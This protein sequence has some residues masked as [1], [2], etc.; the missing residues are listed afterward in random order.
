MT[1]GR[2]SA[3]QAPARDVF[4][5]SC[6]PSPIKI[7]R[8]RNS[9]A[10]G[11]DLHTMDLFRRI[12]S[13]RTGGRASALRRLLYVH[14]TLL[15]FL[16]GCVPD[17]PQSI[18]HDRGGSGGGDSVLQISIEPSGPIDSA[19]PILRARIAFEG[20]SSV[21]LERVFFVEG[22]IGPA[23]LRQIEKGALSK[24]LSG[25]V[26]PAL[27]WIEA[28]SGANDD[29][30]IV[31]PLADLTLGATYAIAS[32]DPSFVSYIRVASEDSTPRLER[33][34]PPIDAGATLTYGVWCGSPE[35]SPFAIE[36][37]LSPD[38]PRGFF[39]AG[40]VDG[41]GSRCAR[42]E[43][44]SGAD[45][46]GDAPLVGP[47]ALSPQGGPIRLDPRPFTLDVEPTA[48]DVVACS[49]EEV[50]FG[51]GCARIED[52]RLFGRAPKAPLLWAVGGAG[53]DSVFVTT[54]EEPF[55]LVP[56]PPETSI[57]LDVSVVDSQGILLRDVVFST[58]LEPMAHI[59]VNEVLANPL[60]AEPAQEW[61]E[62]VNDGSL[63]AS[64]AG[65]VLTDIGGK[66]ELPDVELPAGSYA[67]IVNEAFLE[68]DELDPVPA[69]G[70]LLVRVPKL[71]KGGLSNSGE[72]LK[73][74][75]PAGVTVSRAPSG[76]RMKPGW[77][78]SRMTPYAPDG[79]SASFAISVPTPG[80]RNFM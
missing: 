51:P 27:R 20:A 69:P 72:P 22:E 62:L 16:L 58:T 56:L 66:T 15:L 61:V 1:P 25:R 48:V 55:V 70:T 45:A 52:D 75:D 65:Y 7:D 46:E 40:V 31:A 60:G 13:R 4:C 3:A 73:L 54:D 2:R 43:A 44:S 78:L 23:H 14:T 64:L 39:R 17:L 34:W 68:D 49:P 10:P 67:L 57:M 24:A 47:P 63:P 80:A 35:F 26:V 19:P 5:A 50:P 21:D 6:P 79:A 33:I 59:V 77:S 42:F 18:G 76:A 29:A 9:R 12:R 53:L 41:V 74:L 11:I 32:G 28:G 37:H 30:L 38:G 36:A 8:S 71:G